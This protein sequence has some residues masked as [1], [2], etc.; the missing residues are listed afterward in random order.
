MRRRGSPLALLVVLAACGSQSAAELP[1]PAGPAPAA[2]PLH[3]GRMLAVL[4][5]RARRLELRDARSH[6]TLASAP[7]GAGPT[8]VACLDDGPCYV[9]DRTGHALL[10]VRTQ[11][12]RVVRRVYLPCAPR[13]L[14][15]DRSRRRLWIT[16]PSRHAVA[17]LPA[18]GR[19]HI[20]RL[21]PATA[22][23]EAHS[24]PTLISSHA[25]AKPPPA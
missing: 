6:R 18:H 9:L 21:R 24:S 4:L 13:D 10:V 5:P 16:L 1:P 15:L 22:S 7:V 25:R 8:H 11:P 20:L 2:V 19:P 23:A 12:L 3:G 17:E 14:T